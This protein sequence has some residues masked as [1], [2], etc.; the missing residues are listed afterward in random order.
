MFVD[1]HIEKNEL[2]C[3]KLKGEKEVG[4]KYKRHEDFLHKFTEEA[5]ENKRRKKTKSRKMEK[6]E[7]E[8][9]S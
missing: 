4:L 5:K 2:I 6:F 1:M 8:K 7:E 3:T 9:K